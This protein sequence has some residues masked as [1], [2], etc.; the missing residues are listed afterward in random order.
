MTIL[1]APDCGA[2]AAAGGTG[3]ASSSSSYSSSSSFSS[4]SFSFSSSSIQF[5]LA[6]SSLSSNSSNLSTAL[7]AALRRGIRCSSSSSSSSSSLTTSPRS[8][9]IAARITRGS[10]PCA[11]CLA[12]LLKPRHPRTS[13]TRSVSR[14]ASTKRSSPSS[15]MSAP[16]TPSARRFTRLWDSTSKPRSDTSFAFMCDVPSSTVSKLSANDW[17]H[18]RSLA[19]RNSIPSSLAN[20]V[21]D[22]RRHRSSPSH[23][24]GIPHR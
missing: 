10:P 15:V 20:P 23:N 2:A 24:E 22:A 8:F 3:T 16:A 12:A 17:A 21:L 9:L 1:R 5:S 14:R 19:A 4:S 11:A 7:A 13:T 6:S 18:G